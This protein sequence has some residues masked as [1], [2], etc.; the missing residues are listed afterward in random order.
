MG[1]SIFLVTTTVN[2]KP[3]VSDFTKESKIDNTWRIKGVDKW[4][5]GEVKNFRRYGY[6]SRW[7]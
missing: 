4:K 3:G 5:D 6:G 7:R 2:D 1:L